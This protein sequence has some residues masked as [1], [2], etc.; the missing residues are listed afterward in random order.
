MRFKSILLALISYS[1]LAQAQ[2]ITG[3][4][5]NLEFK[6]NRIIYTGSVKLVRGSSVLKADKV[7][8][9]LTE[10]G[11]PVKIVATGNVQYSEPGRKATSRYAEYDLMQ[12]VIIL[13]GEAHVE[14]DN[15]ILEADEIVYDRKRQTL[16]AKGDM[17]RTIYIEEEGNEKVRHNKGNSEKE[18][19][20]PEKGED[21]S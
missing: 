3:E 8:I 18:G 5:K 14:E 17:V 15:S 11:K 12:E 19:N 9:F 7:V 4:A 16:Q 13:K 10:E 2:P 1:L 21:D 6:D 20:I